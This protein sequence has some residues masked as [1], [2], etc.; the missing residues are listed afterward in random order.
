MM[1]GTSLTLGYVG[2]SSP[3]N[4]TFAPYISYGVRYVNGK[5][6]K[7]YGLTRTRSKDQKSAA[8]ARARGP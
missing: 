2:H 4:S 8:R 3:S 1:V 7:F 5:D 6:R